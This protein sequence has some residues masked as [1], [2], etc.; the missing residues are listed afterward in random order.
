MYACYCAVTI[1][2]WLQKKTKLVKAA[3]KIL[4]MEGTEQKHQIQYKSNTTQSND[5]R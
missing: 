1:T 2:F 4:D 5:A 3:C